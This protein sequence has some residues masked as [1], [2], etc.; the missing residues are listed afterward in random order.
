ML[1]K[2]GVDISRL[3]PPIRKKLSQVYAMYKVLGEHM[4][5]TCT[6]DGNHSAGSLHYADLGIDLAYPLKMSEE[7][8]D[9]LEI[10]FGPDY[11]IVYEQSH[12]HIE[13]DPR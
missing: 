9:A 2:A 7:F 3:K 11:D 5:I 13:Y 4:I 8:K 10:V 1:I 6:Y 12:I